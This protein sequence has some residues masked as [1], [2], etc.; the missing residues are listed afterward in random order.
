[1]KGKLAK[2]RTRQGPDLAKRLVK[3]DP[4]RVG[5]IERS[6]ASDRRDADDAVL[7]T[8]EKLLGQAHALLAENEGITRR[9]G[10]VEVA[11][12]CGSAEEVGAAVG[13]RSLPCV[14]EMFE[15]QVPAHI[16]EVP[17]IDPRSP[18]TVLIDS[19][20]QGAYQ[21]HRRTDGGAE[22]PH[23]P[24]VRWNLGF[25]QDDVEGL[26]KGSG[27][28]ARGR[29]RRARHAYEHIAHVGG[30]GHELDARGA[31]TVASRL[32][33][34]TGAL[35]RRHRKVAVAVAS[36]AAALVLARGVA[37]AA[38]M[39]PTPERLFI[40]P[41]GLMGTSCQDVARDPGG[42]PTGFI[43]THPGMIPNSFPCRPNNIAW[44]NLMSELGYAIAPSAF[45]PARTT[46]FGGFALSLEAS[47][48]HINANAVAAGDSSGTQ[49]WHLGTRGAVD[50]A[51]HQFSIV[52]NNPDS[53]LQIYSVQARKGL[54][55]GLEIAGVL[56]YVANT[57]LW[58]GGG[59]VHWALLEGYRTGILGYLPD[60]AIGGGVRTLG[61]SPKFFLTTIGMDAQ[62]SKPF[63]L[64]DSAVLTPY[65][66]AQRLII[67]ADSTVV[68]LTPTVD[69][70]QQC[71]YQGVNPQDGTPSCRNTLTTTSGQQIANNSDFNNNVTF[72]KARIHR[73]RGIAG[74]TYRYEILYLAGQFAADLEDPSTENADLG[75]SGARQW[76][77]S[78]EAGVFF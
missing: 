2:E 21:V 72:H 49:Y 27:A 18:D 61:G 22:A 78:L 37:R 10:G 15:V 7:K 13:R 69:P 1:V 73:W 4:D 40:E 55:F 41:P 12:L 45:H 74:V 19:E 39:D 75:I 58:L 46:G 50:P 67:V 36:F 32:E 33:P 77:I 14:Q 62:V 65:L 51:N 44:A 35:L 31:Q 66:G 30:E 29:P 48:A 25:D 52:N 56:G 47:F 59:D 23:I 28:Q 3:G 34:R 68:D 60:I 6:H 11:L 24:G 42:D 9:V 16:D 20:A 5:E 38:D 54:P 70:L 43:E 17:V 76:T 64:A 63:A 26:C 53:L 8:R 57:S 71:G